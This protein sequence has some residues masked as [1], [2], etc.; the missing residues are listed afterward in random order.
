MRS[1]VSVEKVGLGVAVEQ[2]VVLVLPVERDQVP[3]SS[4]SCP[5]FAWAGRRSGGA[6]FAQLALQDQGRAARFEN[7]STVARSAP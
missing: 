1:G 3:A 5:G 7:T 4:R 6:A 2:S